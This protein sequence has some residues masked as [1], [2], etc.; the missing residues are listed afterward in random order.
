MWM[1]KLTVSIYSP[2]AAAFLA[3]GRDIVC[4]RTRFPDL[5]SRSSWLGNGGM[6]SLVD[7]IDGST[8]FSVL[9]A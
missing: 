8:V 4:F 1:E 3:E 6:S 5:P 9:G 2:L 7:N